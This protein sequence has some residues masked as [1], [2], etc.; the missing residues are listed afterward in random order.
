MDNHNLISSTDHLSPSPLLRLPDELL[1]RII[2]QAYNPG[3]LYGPLCRRLYPLQRAHLLAA[4][5]TWTEAGLDSFCRLLERTPALGALVKRLEMYVTHEKPESD[6]SG[7]TS[8]ARLVAMLAKL[9]HV[10]VVAVEGHSS[11][12]AIDAVLFAGELAGAMPELRVVQVAVSCFARAYAHVRDTQATFS[13]LLAYPALEKASITPVDIGDA[14]VITFEGGPR[15][16]RPTVLVLDYDEDQGLEGLRELAP[17]VTELSL[18]DGSGER[19]LFNSRF[20]AG[21]D[22]LRDLT[23]WTIA[24]G[25]DPRPILETPLQLF[26]LSCLVRLE[27]GSFRF[28]VSLVPALESLPLLSHLVFQQLAHATDALLRRLVNR[29]RL[30]QLARL[31]LDHVPLD[32]RLPSGATHRPVL[33]WPAGCTPAGQLAAYKAAR[34]AGIEVDGRLREALGLGDGE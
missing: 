28:D 1:D 2:K 34:K 8:G 21:L 20:C 3:D 33:Y 5:R 25:Y 32:H 26:D 11:R 18:A 13:R 27:L 4:V 7:I 31:T 22:K 29:Q 19:A 24:D 30:P 12:E 15:F 16:K 14:T 23:L 9:E 6:A 17:Y 10:E